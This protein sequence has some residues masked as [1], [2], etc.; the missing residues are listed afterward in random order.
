MLLLRNGQLKQLPFL[1]RE[2]KTHPP[3][4]HRSLLSPA[5]AHPGHSCTRKVDQLITKTKGNR[6]CITCCPSPSS[7][8]GL[9]CLPL[10]GCWCGMCDFWHEKLGAHLIY[11]NCGATIAFRSPKV[12]VALSTSNISFTPLLP[13]AQATPK[14]LLITVLKSFMWQFRKLQGQ[15]L[16]WGLYLGGIIWFEC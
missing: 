11:L 7:S 9:C 14:N 8:H 6:A 10:V 15:V 1:P 4:W 13:S 16:I 12:S 5:E 2:L 3:G